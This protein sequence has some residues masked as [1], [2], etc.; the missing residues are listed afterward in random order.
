MMNLPNALTKRE[1]EV[2]LLLAR[3][4]FNKEV[5][6]KL[7]VSPRTIEGYKYQIYQKL[8][9]DSSILMI[10]KMLELKLM[11]YNKGAFRLTLPNQQDPEEIL[12]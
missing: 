6:D 8:G 2:A 5:A 7:S 1:N 11:K 4:L 10:N 3:G 9:V 12:P